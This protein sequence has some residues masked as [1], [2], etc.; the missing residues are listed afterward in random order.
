MDK[1]TQRTIDLLDDI[2]EEN[3]QLADTLAAIS[4]PCILRATFAALPVFAKELAAC[5]LE[6]KAPDGY[7]PKP[8][9]RCS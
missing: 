2:A 7:N 5:L 3:P 6:N 9:T 4:F 8:D 1:A